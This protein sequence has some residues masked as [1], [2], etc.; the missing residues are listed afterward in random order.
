[1]QWVCGHLNNLQHE[2]CQKEKK[3]QCIK[4]SATSFP[5]VI[6]TKNTL[7]CS[8]VHS[9]QGCPIRDPLVFLFEKV[10]LLSAT[11]FN[12]LVYAFLPS[13]CHFSPL[14]CNKKWA[15]LFFKF[16]LKERKRKRLKR[17]TGVEHSQ[18]LHHLFPRPVSFL[19]L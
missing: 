14:H 6:F 9:N 18:L 5:Y 8:S 15:C 12:T 13:V 11:T 19:S 1:M 10:I 2:S 4:C 16:C 17:V 7:H 3:K